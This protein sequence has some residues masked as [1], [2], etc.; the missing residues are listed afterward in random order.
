MDQFKRML[1][2]RQRVAPSC[3]LPVGTQETQHNTQG[4]ATRHIAQ[5]AVMPEPCPSAAVGAL[6]SCQPAS[7]FVFLRLSCSLVQQ[8]KLRNN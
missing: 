1:Q 5:H 8:I 4:S 6:P 7:L 3:N 2:L